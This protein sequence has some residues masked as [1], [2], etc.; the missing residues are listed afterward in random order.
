MAAGCSFPYAD[1]PSAATS[2]TT[3][4]TAPD[5]TTTTAPTP[6]TP[7]GPRDPADLLGPADRLLLQTPDGIQLADTAGLHD[8]DPAGAPFEGQP[9]FSARGSW[10]AWV[11]VAGNQGAVAVVDLFAYEPGLDVPPVFTASPPVIPFYLGFDRDESRLAAL[12]GAGDV[13][14][15]I[16]DLQL[17]GPP[18]FGPIA[19]TDVPLFPSWGPG[20]ALALN[21]GGLVEVRSGLTGETQIVGDATPTAPVWL[22]DRVVFVS[23]EAEIVAVSDATAP[24]GEE[25]SSETLASVGG[26]ARVFAG[27]DGDRLAVTVRGNPAGGAS[28]VSFRQTDPDD[29][30]PL[31]GS[32]EAPLTDGVWVLDPAFGAITQVFNEPVEGVF[33][34]PRGNELLLVGAGDD[35]IT[36]TVVDLAGVVRD[37]IG[38]VAPTET[39]AQN[40]LP[41][42]DTYAQSMTLWSPDGSR[43]VSPELLGGA[44]HLVIHAVGQPAQVAVLTA[45]EMGVWAPLPN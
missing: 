39:F 10:A 20:G 11:Q 41:F 6:T 3:T 35:G 23:D 2:T 36:W 9:T 29:A 4:T 24:L 19:A 12:G 37:V 43:F 25:P 14:L 13:A 34:S 28:P 17:D 26:L 15:T 18:V 30:E 38:P 7:P 32:P 45:G 16:G 5:S 31:P 40:Y 44:P 33:W 21:A 42:L 1:P 27:P 8:L 22:G